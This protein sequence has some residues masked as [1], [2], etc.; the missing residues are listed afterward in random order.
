[1]LNQNFLC[2]QKPSESEPDTFEPLPCAIEVTTKMREMRE[3]V[4][5]LLG[6]WSSPSKFDFDNSACGPVSVKETRV[7]DNLN[8]LLHKVTVIRSILKSRAKACVIIQNQV[9]VQLRRQQL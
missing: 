9:R 5:A 3:E 4:N 8:Y 1:M 2:R 7:N 6:L